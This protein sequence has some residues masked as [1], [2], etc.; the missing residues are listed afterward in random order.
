[1]TNTYLLNTGLAL[2]E[3]YAAQDIHAIGK[4]WVDVL[5]DSQEPDT[6]PHLRS[7]AHTDPVPRNLDEKLAEYDTQER[8]WKTRK[9]EI[10]E[11]E[12]KLSREI[13]L[14]NR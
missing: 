1:M 6:A 10:S 12:Y 8:E 4:V 13:A 7:Q 2:V 14:R 3:A 11:A 5:S 9:Q